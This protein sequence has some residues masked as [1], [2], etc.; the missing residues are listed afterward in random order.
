LQ[1]GILAHLTSNWA[2]VYT[3]RTEIST[4]FRSAGD[5]VTLMQ[6]CPDKEVGWYLL[7][8]EHQQLSLRIHID[9]NIHDLFKPSRL[10]RLLCGGPE[11][12]VFHHRPCISLK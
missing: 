2:D 9:M 11:R 4:I 10:K 12:V 1:I 3:L 7:K 6:L 5:W 8:V